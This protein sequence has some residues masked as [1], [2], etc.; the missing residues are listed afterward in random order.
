MFASHITVVYE[1]TSQRGVIVVDLVN[2]VVDLRFVVVLARFKLLQKVTE[3]HVALLSL[4]WD[5]PQATVGHIVPQHLAIVAI[6]AWIFRGALQ[7][8]SGQSPELRVYP[9]PRGAAITDGRLDNGVALYV[10][11]KVSEKR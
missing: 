9:D 4:A 6:Q 11:Q 8:I 1:F 7:I 3:N 10:I 2:D 5:G